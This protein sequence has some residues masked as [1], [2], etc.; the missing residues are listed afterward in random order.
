MQ[1]TLMAQPIRVLIADDSARTREGLRVLFAAW[2]EIVII[3]EAADGREAIRLAEECQPDIVLLDVHMPV[4]DGVQA[5]QIIKQQCP[6]TTVVVLTM[7]AV[8]QPAALAAGADS[9]VIKGDPPERLLTA[10]GVG[11]D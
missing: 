8:D 7:Y 4:L 2:P 5:T 6:G 11:V 10:L 1:G 3:G 9:F